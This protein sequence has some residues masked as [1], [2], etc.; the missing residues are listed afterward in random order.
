[1]EA[2]GSYMQYGFSAK[3]QVIQGAPYRDPYR[4]YAKIVPQNIMHDRRVV[5][6][7]TFAALVIPVNMQPNPALIEKQRQ[8]E[9]LRKQRVDNMRQRKEDELLR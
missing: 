9:L 8:E 6:G 3:P 5:R 2:S 7:N 1:M 4:E